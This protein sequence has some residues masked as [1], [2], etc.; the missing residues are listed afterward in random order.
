MLDLEDSDQYGTSSSQN[1]EK[2][3]KK[4]QSISYVINNAPQGDQVDEQDENG[5]HR[6]ANSKNDD[7]ESDE[8]RSTMM[9]DDYKPNQKDAWPKKKQPALGMRKNTNN[10]SNNSNN[11]TLH[12]YQINKSN[13]ILQETENSLQRI[14]GNFN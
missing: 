12:K 10:N 7:T 14:N 5:A 11:R 9:E 6:E 3:I 2:S 4:N 13:S 8:F 1:S